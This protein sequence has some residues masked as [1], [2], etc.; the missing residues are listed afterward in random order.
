VTLIDVYGSLHYAG[1]RTLQH[2]LPDPSGTEGPAVVLRMRG[3][4]ILGATFFTVLAGYAEQ[5]KAVGGRL[6][7][8][9]LDPSLIAQ[10]KRTG[11]I[12][13]DEPVKLY[14]ASSVIG[15]SS[16]QAFHDAQAWV[17]ST[18]SGPAA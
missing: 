3:R 9:G 7:V 16:L 18:P 2:H 15:E 13:D 1:A 10:T 17:S 11:T 4:S 12:P 14:E 6:Y 8:S 5:L